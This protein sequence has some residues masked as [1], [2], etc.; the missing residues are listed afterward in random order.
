M[1]YRV[2]LSDGSWFRTT[3]DGIKIRD[4]GEPTELPTLDT[5][6]GGA[7]PG[8]TLA[9][10]SIGELGELSCVSIGVPPVDNSGYE[11]GGM[12]VVRNYVVLDAR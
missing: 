2:T 5:N 11:T 7:K 9:V 10:K 3:M 12:I 4:G 1:V 6:H 8:P